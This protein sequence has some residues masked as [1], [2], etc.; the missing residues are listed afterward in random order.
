MN[1]GI[2]STLS[3]EDGEECSAR[4]CGS[5]VWALAIAEKSI[6]GSCPVTRAL[7][8]M[9]DRASCHWVVFSFDMLNDRGEL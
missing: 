7:V 1:T 5:V 4:I 2:G 9:R 8:S 3:E 6:T